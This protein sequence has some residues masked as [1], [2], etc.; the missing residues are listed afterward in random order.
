ML[1]TLV[2]LVVWA[3]D[4][5]W[6]F[7][8]F[9][10]VVALLVLLLA[11]LLGVPSDSPG[12]ICAVSAVLVGI[13]FGTPVLFIWGA[14]FTAPLI[15]HFGEPGQAVI[16][17]SE[18]T[19]NMMNEQWVERYFVKLQKADGTQ[20]DTQFDSSDFNV[21][22]RRNRVRYPSQGEPF[23]VHYLPKRPQSFVILMPEAEGKR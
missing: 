5:V 14:S 23:A 21:Y 2:T 7:P 6:P 13:P 9:L 8:V 3:T 17:D 22:P 1:E 19:N 15:Y 16:V 18:E 11:R 4:A 20:I 12:L 10:I